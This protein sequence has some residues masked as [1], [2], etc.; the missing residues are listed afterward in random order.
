MSLIAYH[1]D[2]KIKTATVKRM[3]A[4]IN[5]DEL[6]RGVG[7]ENG[8]GCAVGCTLE[9]YDHKAF[10]TDLGIPEWVAHL[11]DQ[12]HE[13]TS[14]EVWPTLQL[15]FLEAVPIGFSEWERVRHRLGAF[16]QARN[17]ARIEALGRSPELRGDLLDAIQAVKDLHEVMEQSDE[18]WSAAWS[19]AESAR[20]VAESAAE[21]ARS[22]AW[23]ARSAAESVAE[24]AWSAAESAA[25][26][27]ESARSAEF[28]AI[29]EE[30]IRLLEETP[31][32]AQ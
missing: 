26:S 17:I 6:V 31:K 24:S 27:A 13:N 21:S 2:P 32:E 7:F 30:L 9:K 10:E 15:R 11:N 4:H 23:S 22:V 14:D 1:N 29:A 3:Q 20:S 8:R 28:D 19:A 5:A 12:L 18:L 16:I 25:W